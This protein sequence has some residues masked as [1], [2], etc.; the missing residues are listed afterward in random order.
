MTFL[1]QATQTFYLEE[2]L[3]DASENSTFYENEFNGAGHLTC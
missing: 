2:S 1:K 3:S